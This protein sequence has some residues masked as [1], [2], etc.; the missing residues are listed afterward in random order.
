MPWNLLTRKVSELRDQYLRVEKY[1]FRKLLM[2][3]YNF[4]AY[5]QTLEKCNRIKK[6]FYVKI[7]VFCTFIINDFSRYLQ[8]THTSN[9]L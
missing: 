3:I 8:K 1:S 2:V 5:M 4:I 7:Y 9:V 6:I